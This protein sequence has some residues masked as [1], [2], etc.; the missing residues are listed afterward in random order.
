MDGIIDVKDYI[1]TCTQEE[2]K[3]NQML[4]DECCKETINFATV[5]ELLKA[6]ADPLGGTEATGIRLLDHIYGDIVGGSQYNNSVDLP[7]ITELFLKYGMNIDKPKIPYDNANSINPAW[8]FGFVTNENAIIALK[9]LLDR[10]LSYESFGLFCDHTITDFFHIE[11]GD[12]QND[13]FWNHECTWTFKM[14]LLGASYD[15]IL[16]NDK[17]L[18]N[19]LCC[20]Y[21]SYDIKNFRNWDKYDYY[22]D[23]SRCV[24]SPELYKS[25]IHIYE[26]ESGKEVWTIGVGTEG[27]KLLGL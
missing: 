10:G 21:N 27:R 20:D 8:E 12:P 9:M 4:Y 18:K 13:E 15:H 16:N 3:L 7:R 25:I 26:K 14:M 24:K 11:C 23:T 5:E 2:I 17:D 1:G 6:G 22:F 19:F